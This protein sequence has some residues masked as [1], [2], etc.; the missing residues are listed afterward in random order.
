MSAKVTLSLSD[1]TV[2][3]ARAAAQREGV[4]LST[5][6]D[7]VAYEQALRD[8]FNAHAHAISRSGLLLE[9]DAL[10]DEDEV[11]TVREATLGGSRRASW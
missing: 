10:A 9:S 4:S 7:R 3:V 1:D 8:V 11:A 6:I 5:W 2:D